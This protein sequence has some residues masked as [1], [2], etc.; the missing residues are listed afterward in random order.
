MWLHIRCAGGWTNKLYDYFEREQ[1]KL[2]LK[3][4]AQNQ[5]HNGGGEPACRHC[6]RILGNDS[7]FSTQNIMK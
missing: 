2:C 3:Q 4:S 1:A 5:Q 6:Q 7:S